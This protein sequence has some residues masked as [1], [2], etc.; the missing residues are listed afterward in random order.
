MF[1]VF[2]RFWTHAFPIFLASESD[3]KTS[4]QRSNET[5]PVSTDITALEMKS[6]DIREQG[7]DVPYF[8]FVFIC[9]TSL[10]SVQRS[11]AWVTRHLV[12]ISL[13]W[14]VSVSSDLSRHTL[15]FVLLVLVKNIKFWRPCPK[16][17]QLEKQQK[18]N[19]I[20]ASQQTKTI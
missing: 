3:E 18:G 15:P 5:I 10:L 6:D 8:R 13:W 20:S 4:I 11:L 2:T 1:L 17:H 9:F 12:K 7:H 14:L 19:C 16:E